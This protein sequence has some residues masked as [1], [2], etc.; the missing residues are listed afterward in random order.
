MCFSGHYLFASN[1]SNDTGLDS[2]IYLDTSSYRQH[3]CLSFYY[4]TNWD[5]QLY[6]D[7]LI[8]AQED[9]DAVGFLDHI[10]FFTNTAWKHSYVDIPEEVEAIVFQPYEEVAI[11]DLLLREGECPFKGW[12]YTPNIRFNPLFI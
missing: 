11:D 9:G 12:C 10:E 4:A 6:I 8:T 2:E 3:I 7:L 1:V 5:G